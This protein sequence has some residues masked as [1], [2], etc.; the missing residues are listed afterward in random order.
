MVQAYSVGA[1]RM[2][3]TIGVGTF[4]RVKLATHDK[5]G[6]KVAIKII[7]RARMQSMEMHEKILR[8]ISI[9]QRLG[10][11]PHIVRL[12]ELMDTPTDIFMVMEYVPGGELFD[13][14]VQRSRLPEVEARVFF[15]QIISGVEYCHHHMICHRDL[16]PENVFL[17]SNKSVK[18][19][20]FGLS[21]FMRDGDFLKT[22]CGSP[23]YAAPEVV[24]GKAYA[25][26][27]VD[28]WSCGVIL[29]ALLCGSLP[30]DDEHVPNL[31][32]KI[33]RGNF[34]LPGHLSE[35]ARR[36]LIRMLLVDPGTRISLKE[37]RRHPWVRENSLIP[38]PVWRPDPLQVDLATIAAL[39]ELGYT[40]DKEQIIR[41]Q[42]TAPGV[43]VPKEI[44]AYNL[45]Q[46]KKRTETIAAQ[47]SNPLPHGAPPNKKPFAF[48]RGV[49]QRHSTAAL[50]QVDYSPLGFVS[51]TTSRNLFGIDSQYGSQSN[52]TSST[53]RS[54][55]EGDGH[56]YTLS[57]LSRQQSRSSVVS[58]TQVPDSPKWKPGIE[59][60]L[61][62]ATI[63]TAIF[64]TL[65][66]IGYEWHIVSQHRVWCR[67]RLVSQ[68][69]PMTCDSPTQTDS[70]APATNSSNDSRITLCIQVF[71]APGGKGAVNIQ[72][73]DG[74]LA[75]G[76]RCALSTLFAIYRTLAQTQQQTAGLTSARLPRKVSS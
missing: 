65:R 60:S 63:M 24:S 61:D 5:T 30:F 18:V 14:I 6:Q 53:R 29:Y 19:G 1:Y 27:E 55:N 42:S 67:P 69:V 34:N 76:M 52:M 17:E 70:S 7:N 16:K 50:F 73:F 44:I 54:S 11:H 36:L 58:S 57:G 49:K 4:G 15:Q 33:K 43:F 72:V 66:S 40:I 20:D 31:F 45:L 68:S 28:I 35:N 39:Q 25:G 9:L 46:D 75:A 23:N 10:A 74:S 22:S 32:R 13:Y 51:F 48:C 21:N 2:A 3:Y 41:Y 38:M 26:P 71:R 12:Y 56:A 47:G 8:E 59:S 62:S 37:I 64:H